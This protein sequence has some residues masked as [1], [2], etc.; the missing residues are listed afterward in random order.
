MKLYHIPD[1]A[2]PT[3]P[4]MTRFRIVTTPL[5]SVMIHGIR[6]PDDARNLHNHPWAFLTVILRGGYEQQIVPTLDAA[7]ADARRG[8]ASP[9]SVKRA[10]SVGYMNRN[11]YHSIDSLLRG[12][13]PTWSLVFA[14]RRKGSWGFATASGHVDHDPYLE[15]IDPD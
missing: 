15:G 11:K 4:Y 5:F 1:M 2:D 10:G 13:Q 7:I 9:T 6:L 3:R 12:D 14:G 8:L